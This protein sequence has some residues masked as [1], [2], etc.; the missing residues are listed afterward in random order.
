LQVR[1]DLVQFLTVHNVFRGPD[2]MFDVSH[3]ITYGTLKEYLRRMSADGEWG[4]HIMLIAAAELYEM[5]IHIISSVGP[6]ID[7]VPRNAIRASYLGH[8]H[9]LHYRSL[10]PL[11]DATL[12]NHSYYRI[13]TNIDTDANSKS[14]T[15]SNG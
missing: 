11:P 12:L 9:E 2:G 5:R 8:L 3:H 4:D 14:L 13:S 1:R 7:I 10:L 6:P 15:F